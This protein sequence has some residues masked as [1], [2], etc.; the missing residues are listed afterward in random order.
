MQKFRTCLY[1]SLVVAARNAE[2]LSADPADVRADECAGTQWSKNSMMR[3]CYWLCLIRDLGAGKKRADQILA[4]VRIA[5]RCVADVRSLPKTTAAVD[6]WILGISDAYRYEFYDKDMATAFLVVPE[7]EAAVSIRMDKGDS[8]G[9]SVGPCR[10]GHAQPVPLANRLHLPRP[11]F[12]MG[13]GRPGMAGWDFLKVGFGDHACFG[14]SVEEESFC[15][16]E[17]S[18]SGRR[19]LGAAFVTACRI[20]MVDSPAISVQ[21]VRGRDTV[22]MALSKDLA[23]S[24]DP[25]FLEKCEGTHARVLA[26]QWHAARAEERGEKLP[27][28]FMIERVDEGDALADE[29]V[30]H[31]RM[32]GSVRTDELEGRYGKVDPRGMGGISVKGGTASYVH[33]SASVDPVID[34]FLKSAAELRRLRAPFRAGPAL[35]VA[36][37]DVLDEGKASA[38]DLSRLLAS[39]PPLRD[40]LLA[41]QA[42]IDLAGEAPSHGEVAA[43]SGLDPDAAKSMAR[44][45]RYLGLAETKGGRVSSAGRAR[46]V[47]GEALSGSIGE[48]EAASDIISIPDLEDAGVPQ[49]AVIARLGRPEGE[50]EPLRA[51]GGRS[52]LYWTRKGAPESLRAEAG[53]RLEKLCGGM[54]GAVRAVNFP[55]TAAYAALEARKAGLPIS[56]LVALMAARHLSRSKKLLPSGE[57]WEYPIAERAADFLRDRA[58]DEFTADEILS[59]IRIA[60][61][62]RAVLA[63]RLDDLAANGR[64]VELS[65]GVWACARDAE[66]Q[67]RSHHDSRIRRKALGMLRAR[68]R[69]MD[70]GMLIGYLR[71]FVSDTDARR[72]LPDHRKAVADA[73]AG[74][75]SDGL[76]SA[77][78]G[79]CRIRT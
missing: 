13:G 29:V 73:V 47:L 3:L 28:V 19:H 76:V 27:E 12:E 79:T 62:D 65:D 7:L 78:D 67:I 33:K 68:P 16:I 8:G 53:A 1:D 22:A 38:W 64:A 14:S 71:R 34:A 44:W 11:K 43:A 41:V 52:R 59:G 4:P 26:V 58:R 77:A 60:G 30:G 21:R 31:V 61:K 24:V 70:R 35:Q 23:K 10:F 25:G 74:L 17:S 50:F 75:E 45:L 2:L 72:R 56:H 37:G 66:E 9:L 69:G 20:T 5:A 51:G 48:I 46:D 6:G 49:S 40:A 57:S 42:R 18:Q 55:F 39:R 63:E 32:R 15:E 36:P 54:L